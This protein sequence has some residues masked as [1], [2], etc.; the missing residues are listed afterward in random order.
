MKL[1]LIVDKDFP[2]IGFDKLMLQVY[3]MGTD[4]QG[5]QIGFM[6]IPR[7]GFPHTVG[8]LRFR[9]LGSPWRQRK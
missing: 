6:G 8:I 1:I 4:F 5:V 9:D 7:V 3:I 2:E